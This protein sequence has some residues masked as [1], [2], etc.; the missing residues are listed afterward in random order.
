VSTDALARAIDGLKL[1][2]VAPGR[3][4]YPGPIDKSGKQAF[5][6]CSLRLEGDG[7]YHVVANVRVR[8]SWWTPEEQF[9][10]ISRS[11]IGKPN[12]LWDTFKSKDEAQAICDLNYS[13]NEIVVTAN[14]E[15]GEEVAA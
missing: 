11:Y 12:R 5:T 6:L 14:L 3:Y 9:A 10:I 2:E 7:E 4:A 8:A 13:G 1:V 15:T